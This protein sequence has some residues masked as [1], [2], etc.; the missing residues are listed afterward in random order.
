MIALLTWL[1]TCVAAYTALS[2]DK[3]AAFLRDLP[4]TDLVSIQ[5]GA[6]LK[7]LLV[8]RVSGTAGAT[9]A[10]NF[11]KS[12]LNASRWQIEEDRF[13]DQTPLAR[14]EFVNLMATMDPPGSDPSRVSRLVLAAHY[15]SKRLP[16]GFI[17]ATDSAVPCAIMLYVAR[18][19][20]PQM[21]RNGRGVQLIFFDGE[22]AVND[23]TDTDSIYG[24][25]HLAARLDKE[26]AGLPTVANHKT[27]LQSI[28]M[29]VLLDLLGT[30]DA[31]VPSFFRSTDWAYQALASIEVAVHGSSRVFSNQAAFHMAGQIGD[32]HMPFLQRGTDILHV[33]PVP[34]PRVWHTME[35]DASALDQSVVDDL[36]RIF[37]LFTAEALDLPWPPKRSR[38][39]L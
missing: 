5:N 36:A 16:P 33:I 12:S 35:D 15:D 19:L 37:A 30:S 1:L 2:G 31:S 14:V 32:D 23:W 22:E 8:P 27:R 21:L 4:S 17:G 13:Y 9:E 24:A 6:Y 25:R 7:P 34:F 20:A 28:D 38:E 18:T 10:L 26:P 3:R 29:F 11:L 39:E